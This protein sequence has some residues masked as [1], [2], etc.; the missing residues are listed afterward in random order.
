MDYSPW[1]RKE[2]D[3]TEWL[4]ISVSLS[5]DKYKDVSN[6][7]LNRHPIREQVSHAGTKIHFNSFIEILPTFYNTYFFKYIIQ[8]FLE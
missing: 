8:W 7:Q 5:W 3:M 1:G 4:T 2:L 6:F